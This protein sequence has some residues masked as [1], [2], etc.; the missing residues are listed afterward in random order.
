MAREPRDTSSAIRRTYARL[1]A[2]RIAAVAWTTRLVFDGAI[3]S[4][5]TS[6]M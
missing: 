2:S 3:G 1:T 5:W 6:A 4:R